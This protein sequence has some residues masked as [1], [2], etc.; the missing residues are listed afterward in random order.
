MVQTVEGALK[1]PWIRHLKGCAQAYRTEK[2]ER[3][4]LPR[5]RL[6][7]KSPEEDYRKRAAPPPE[8]P[9]PPKEAPKVA[10][11]AQA[12]QGAPKPTISPEQAAPLIKFVAVA[13]R[14]LRSLEAKRTT[15]ARFA[16]ELASA[17]DLKEALKEAGLPAKTA[18]ASFVKA[19]P[20]F[21]MDVPANGGTSYVSLR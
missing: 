13:R 20:E 17:G 21:K 16:Q 7:R 18:V 12:P 10:A 5:R 2:A 8:P 6:N 4:N 9:E 3:A 19:F 1:N 11:A 14:F 15:A